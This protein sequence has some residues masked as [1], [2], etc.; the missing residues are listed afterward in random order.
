MLV[1]GLPT[2]GSIIYVNLKWRVDS[3]PVTEASYS[4]TAADDSTPGTPGITSPVPGSTLPS[5]NVSFDWTGNG[6]IVDDWQLLAGTSVGDN[7]L[8]DSG[9]LADSV[10]SAVV[11]GLPED[12]S[13]IHVTLRWNE[14]GVPSEVNYTYTAAGGAGGGV[15]MMISPADGSTLSGS[16]VTFTWSTEGEAVT[17]W[18]LE[19]GTTPDGTDLF[20]QGMDAAVLSTLVTGLPTDGSTV[21]VNLKWRT[22]G[23]PVNVASYTYTASGP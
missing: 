13:T 8:Y 6:T 18:R 3:G 7:S 1:S 2:D 14:S 17:R 5:G 11:S 19:V 21:Y 12:G 10:T 4:Y 20:V 22:S 16:S 15:P 9:V 23:G